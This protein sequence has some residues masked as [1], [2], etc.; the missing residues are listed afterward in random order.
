MKKILDALEKVDTNNR[1]KV[2]KLLRNL[3][4]D[5]YYFKKIGRLQEI[6]QIVHLLSKFVSINSK[7]LYHNPGKRYYVRGLESIIQLGKTLR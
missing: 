7:E 1:W 5:I 2:N 3:H 6:N 4:S